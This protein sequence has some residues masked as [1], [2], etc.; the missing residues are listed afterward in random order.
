MRSFCI[1]CVFTAVTVAAP[2]DVG[3]PEHTRAADLVK[4]LGHSRYAVR[5]TAAKQLVEMGGAAAAALREGQKSPDEEVRARSATLLP[6]AIALDWQRKSDAYLA[7]PDGRQTPA[8]PLLAEFA[9]LVGKPDAE[10]RKLYA[11]MLRTNGGLMEAATGDPAA[12]RKTLEERVRLLHENHQVGSKAVKIDPADLAVVLLVHAVDKGTAI[13]TSSSPARLLANPGFAEAIADKSV[14]PAFRALVG[15][16]AEALPE[17]DAMSQQLFCMTARKHSIPEAT[18]ALVKA[19]KNTQ[20][21]A[22]TVRALAAE[23]L[24][25]AGGADAIAA[26]ESVLTDKTQVI[27]FGG[28]RNESYQVGDAAL[29]ALVVIQKKNR[30]DYGFGSEM[31]IGFAFGNRQEDIIMLNLHG[32]PSDDARAKA[33]KKWKDENPGGKTSP[34]KGKVE[35]PKTE[36]KHEAPKKK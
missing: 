25:K 8:L 9:R 26:L 33:L 7:D 29:A 2:G 17:H 24:G 31:N 5:E 16:W 35:A 3:T 4:Q 1:L 10:M 19:V 28:N 11:A 22:L 6:Q 23:A 34:A 27:N 36:S 14:G 15:R 21:S 18:P 30:A 20:A 12:A 13:K 32:F